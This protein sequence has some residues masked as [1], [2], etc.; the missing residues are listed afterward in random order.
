MAGPLNIRR[1]ELLERV[2][3]EL[4][5]AP[6]ADCGVGS[7]TTPAPGTPSSN[8]TAGNH[9]TGEDAAERIDAL[10][11]DFVEAALSAA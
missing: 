7:V 1:R 4:R 8:P 3:N 5:A 11:A 10:L 9:R 6:A 2:R